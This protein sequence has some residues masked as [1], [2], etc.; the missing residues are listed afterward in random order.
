MARVYTTGCFK[1]TSY[2]S[3]GEYYRVFQDKNAEVMPAG[4]MRQQY[5]LTQGRVQDIYGLQDH[6]F[7]IDKQVEF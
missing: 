1:I 2:D 3:Q 5:H 6:K 7:Q 4:M